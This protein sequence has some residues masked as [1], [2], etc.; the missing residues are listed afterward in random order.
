MR[1]G[2]FPSMAEVNDLQNSIFDGADSVMLSSEIGSA[3]D[4][5]NT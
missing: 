3:I 1:E 2:V 5:I 4:P